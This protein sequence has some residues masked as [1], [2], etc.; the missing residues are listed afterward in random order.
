VG[1]QIRLNSSF[2]LIGPDSL[3]PAGATIGRALRFL[4]QDVGGAI[5]GVGT[6]A[7]FGGMRYTNAVFAEDEDG[8]PKGWQPLSTDRFGRPRGTNAVTVYPVSSATNI[9]RRGTGKEKDLEAE[10]LQSLNIVAGYMRAPNQSMLYGWEEAT[11]GIL[12]LSSTVANQMSE[13]GWT[14]EKIRQFLWDNTKLP[15]SEVEKTLKTWIQLEGFEKTLR[16]PW[17][18]TSRP[19]NI[20]ILVA[21]GRHPTH[22]YWMQAAQGPKVINAIVKLPAKWDDLLKE[23]ETELGPIPA[24]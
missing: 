4:Q 15:L 12:I 17:P 14:R 18:I 5:P 2:G 7:Q 8:L 16:D 6:M 22:A 24:M 11:P 13:L 19:E 10:A 23:A 21:G 20:M 1:K 3:H 9:L